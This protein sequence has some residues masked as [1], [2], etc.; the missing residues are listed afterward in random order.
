MSRL[1]PPK[2]YLAEQAQQDKSIS[3]DNEVKPIME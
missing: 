1:M 3:E 2:L